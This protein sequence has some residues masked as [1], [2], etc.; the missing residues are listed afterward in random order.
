LKVPTRAETTAATREALLDA[1]GALLDSGGPEAVTLRE[2]G[3]RAGVSRSAL[4]RHFTGKET[5]LTELVTR[6]WAEVGDA[7]VDLRERPDLSPRQRVHDA[8]ISLIT[9]GRARPHLYQLMF[10]T[11]PSEPTAAVRAAERSHE[12]FLEIVGDVDGDT[13]RYEYAA[14][15]MTSAHGIAG[16]ELSGHLT[17]RKWHTDAE[18]LIDLLVRLLP[19]AAQDRVDLPHRRPKPR[20]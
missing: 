14:L 7:L 18:R 17:V 6:A 4:Y 15:L 10:A 20:S 3:A 16:L 1:A 13:L 8:F 5:L 19:S 9:L 11:P 12:L 2:V